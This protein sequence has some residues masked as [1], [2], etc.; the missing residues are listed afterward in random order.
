MRKEPFYNQAA[1]WRMSVKKMTFVILL[2][3][4]KKVSLYLMVIFYVL[5][6]LNHLFN[7][8][9]YEAI[10]P[11]YIGSH[12]I[13]IYLS[14]VCEMILGLL[15]IRLYTR[16]IAAILIVVMLIVFLWLH[17]QMLFDYWT[18]NNK[19]LWFAIIRIPLQFILIWWAYSFTLRKVPNKNF[20]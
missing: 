18:T 17:V 8:H 13:L 14:G 16:K 3:Q 12:E 9:F 6:G 20:I 5:A 11:H 4:M 2:P 7:P 10:M 19:N 15:L 1:I